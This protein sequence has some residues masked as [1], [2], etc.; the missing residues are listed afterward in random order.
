[1]SAAWAS[2]LIAAAAV[3][4]L[5]LLAVWSSVRFTRRYRSFRCR[6]ALPP[7]RRR[8]GRWRLVRS[9]AV[10]VDDV[11]LVRSGPLGLEVVPLATGVPR[12]ATVRPLDARRVRGLG[13]RPVA[14]R[15]HGP[16]G[17]QRE[18]A[19]AEDCAAQLVGPYLLAALPPPRTPRER[20]A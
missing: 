11:L 7:S 12:T 8:A 16:D 20:D 6:I 14:L 2:A 5:A 19:V 1:M 9:R 18:V 17:A 4:P 13:P 3:V 10:W 15:V